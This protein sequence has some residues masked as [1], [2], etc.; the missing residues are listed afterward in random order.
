MWRERY[1]GSS[2]TFNRWLERGGSRLVDL[3]KN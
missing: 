1:A 3:A 2:P